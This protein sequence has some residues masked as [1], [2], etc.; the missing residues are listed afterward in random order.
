MSKEFNKFAKN[1]KRQKYLKKTY[2]KIVDIN[3]KV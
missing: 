3:E 1:E 2:Q